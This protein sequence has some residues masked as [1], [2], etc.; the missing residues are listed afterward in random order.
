MILIRC[1]CEFFRSALPFG[2]MQGLSESLAR[3]HVFCPTR[4]LSKAF[5]I[6]RVNLSASWLAPAIIGD[7][8]VCGGWKPPRTEAIR[9]RTAKNGRFGRKGGQLWHSLN[10]F[11][12]KRLL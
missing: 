10:A 9:E 4:F 11:Y 3:Q 8:L 7:G 5:S 6:S 2:R 12:L 1:D